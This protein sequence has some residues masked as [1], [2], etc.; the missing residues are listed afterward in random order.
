MIMVEVRA[1]SGRVIESRVFSAYSAAAYFY[2]MALGLYG[3]GVSIY[4]SA[5]N[6]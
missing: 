5:K 6:T 4:F 2:E 3:K 1:D